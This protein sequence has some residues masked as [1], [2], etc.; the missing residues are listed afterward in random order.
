MLQLPKII[1]K[2]LSVRIG[3]MMV[4]AMTLL[5][6][7]SMMVMLHYSRKAVKTEAIE[8]AVR[9]LEGMTNNIDNILLSVEQTTG[10]IYFNML[11]YL[12]NP[13]MMSVFAKKLVETNPYVA[14]CAIA[15]K[16][17]FFKGHKHF[18]TYMHYADS[19]GI[20]YADSSIVPD[21]MFGNT[22]YTEQIW[23]TKPMASG[24]LEWLNPLKGMNSDEAPIITYTLPIILPWS[25]GKPVGVIGV[26]M[27]LSLLSKVVQDA[28]PSKNSYC[29]LI[30]RDGT[31]IV[32]PFSNKLMQ[33]TALMVKEQSAKKVA[34][35]MIAGETDY[36]PFRMGDRDL[37]VFYKP[38]KRTAMRV[39]S[40]DD[41]GW[42]AGIVYPE[43]DIFGDYNDL[44]YYVL[45]SLI[46][47]LLLSFVIS[48]LFIHQ[49]LKPL[50]MLSEQAQRIAK[51]DFDETI[52]DSHRED[53]I[54]RLQ[55]NFKLVQQSLGTTMGELKQLKTKLKQHGVELE[56]AYKQ[57]QKADRMKTAFLHNMT[58]QMLE[59]SEA[60][61]KD[62]EALCN[63]QAQNNAAQL[64]A[65]IQ[66]N[67]NAIADLLK[68]MLNMSD[69]EM[70][71]EAEHV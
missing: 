43:D 44:T 28:K 10:N 29:T 5:L 45:V 57:A 46:I 66:K 37:Y 23:F 17:D 36:K 31:Y 20:A 60:I 18:M 4:L 55:G 34:Q 30:D 25:D 41:L 7:A 50:L 38:F 22:P 71:K 21:D 3:L 12:N 9:S 64:T 58:N 42:S 15:F 19:A 53:E 2:T 32:H 56:K 33:Q 65:D 35:A 14:G 63:G 54:G 51:G 11:P 59:P 67:G 16:E 69:E 48:S 52:P 62:V 47:A 1:K 40:T 6:M 68:N 27:S 49:Q 61:S 70:R 13:D 39:R 8:K 24:K 26:D